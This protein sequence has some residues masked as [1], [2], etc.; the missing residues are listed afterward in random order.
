MGQFCTNPGL[1]FGLDSDALGQ[2]KSAVEDHIGQAAAGTMLH[3]GIQQSYTDGV[4]TVQATEGV[5]T[6]G[7]GASGDGATAAQAA[8]LTTDATTFVGHPHLHEEVFGPASLLVACGSTDELIAVAR[9]LDGNL[10]ATLHGTEDDLRDHADL[11]AILQDKVGR[12][13]FNGFPTG[14]EVCPSMHHGGPYPATTDSRSTSVGT[15]AITRFA[16]PLCYQGFPE[17]ALPSEL[18][19]ANPRGILRMI[20]G[21]YTRDAVED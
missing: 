1:V 20:D 8:V 15:A 16:R 19:D 10:T 21:T 6:L 18:H 14:V 13:V 4:A 7:T 2:F 17:A 11:V 9:S 3:A 5:A 12:L